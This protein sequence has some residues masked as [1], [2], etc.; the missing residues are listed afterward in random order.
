MIAESFY[1]PAARDASSQGFN[2]IDDSTRQKAA[3]ES[4]I[5]STTDH[6]ASLNQI[7]ATG[8]MDSSL[9]RG[10]SLSTLG[11][12]L[13][14]DLTI[15]ED[16]GINPPGMHNWADSLYSTGIPPA[17][18][19]SASDEPIPEMGVDSTMESPPLATPAED[20]MT[21]D[22]FE[23]SASNESGHDLIV[24]SAVADELVD[25][26]FEK[27][28]V[29]LPLFRRPK[30]Y[31]EIVSQRY[32]HLSRT[33]EFLLFAMFGL[34]A[35]FS[36]A[37]VFSAEN[38]VDRGNRFIE[39]AT[40]LWEEMCRYQRESIR[41]LP[42]LQ[43]L[44]LLTFNVLQSG[45]SQQAWILSG[46]C[47]RLA[48]DLDLHIIDNDLLSGDSDRREP[49]IDEWLLREEKRRAWWMIWEM[50]TF[51]STLSLR[52]F[53]IDGRFMQVLL[54]VSDKAWCDK[55]QIPSVPL[56]DMAW[57]KLCDSPNQDERAWFL[58]CLSILRQAFEAALLP[59]TSKQALHDAEAAIGC[60]VLALPS[61]FQ[62]E[63][64]SI[65]FDET[66]FSRSNWVVCTLIALQW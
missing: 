49:S 34:S 32:H 18:S 27:V 11:N 4:A 53:T 6:Q 52:P 62:I 20:S 48:Y 24:V 39:R 17:T 47:T 30:F 19:Y 23:D 55:I 33:S 37:A 2:G 40:A 59:G 43:G 66:N 64:G 58:I 3:A 1:A 36:K 26:Y 13:A 50:D 31:S 21:V 7:P 42:C 38:P 63:P 9:A 12:F 5:A 15:T 14:S 35:R 8:A 57:E 65:V 61:T 10:V 22:S 60:F 29:F 28:Q 44:I 54:P 25:L 16:W 56:I 46:A 51:A 41:T 45:P